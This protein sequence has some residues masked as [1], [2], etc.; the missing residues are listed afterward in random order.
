M[1]MQSLNGTALRR[2]RLYRRGRSG[3]R[4]HLQLLDLLA[5]WARSG[6]SRP[7]QV[8][9]YQ[10]AGKQGNYQFHKHVLHHRFCLS[11]G[12]ESYA[13]GKGPDGSDMVA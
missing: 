10:G 9:A 3:D 1:A 11:C 5:N 7:R 8:Q 12:I 6:P 13:D 2:D 4:H